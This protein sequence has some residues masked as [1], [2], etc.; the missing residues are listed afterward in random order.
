MTYTTTGTNR[1][2]LARLA[3]LWVATMMLAL[4]TDGFA[5]AASDAE[6]QAALA[7]L[8]APTLGANL[9]ET[10]EAE[11]GML[12]ACY[13]PRLGLVYRVKGEGLRDQ[14]HSQRHVAFSWSE[15][16]S[17][18]S[19]G[20]PGP[21]GPMGPQGPQGETGP[22]GP[23]G[24]PGPVG[25]QGDEGP[26]GPQGEAGLAGPQGDTGPAGPRGESGPEGPAGSEGP[27]GPAGADGAPGP[28]GPAGAIGPEGPEGPNGPAGADGAPGPVGPAGPAGP[29]GPEGPEGP[30]G[31]QGPSGISGFHI[32]SGTFSV[33]PDAVR[34]G[35]H[36][37]GSGPTDRVFGGGFSV[38]GDTSNYRILDNR[39][40]RDYLWMVQVHNRSN[41][42][43][44]NVTFYAICGR[45]N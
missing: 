2:A 14:C 36:T 42:G 4:P 22:A 35:Q 33:E 34:M 32:K 5:Q 37:C 6:M 21:E 18:N 45:A 25:P 28:A 23:Q 3:G 8:G 44:L 15:L 16:G 41:M 20:V 26:T 7:A 12:Y 10:T 1:N 38:S 43:T 40:N 9:V 27:R 24:E 31:P 19:E 29:A 11:P 30:A 17:P 13:I 39:P